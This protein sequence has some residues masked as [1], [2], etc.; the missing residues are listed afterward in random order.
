MDETR[1]QRWGAASGF[2]AILVGAAAT[3][4]ER[5]SVGV[6]DSAAKIAAHLVDNGQALRAQS[7]L[8]VIGTGALLWFM[9]SLRSFLGMAEGGSTRLSEVAFGAGVAWIT[10]SL[11]AQTFQIGLAGA[12]GGEVS[13]ALIATMDASFVVAGLPLAVMLIA[14]AAVSLRTKVFPAWLAWLS[15]AT[16][17]AQLVSLLGIVVA[18]GPL[19]LD[20]WIT[21]YTPYPLLVVWLTATSAVMVVRLG[22]PRSAAAAD[23]TPTAPSRR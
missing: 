22:K 15:M 9:G 10:L 4:F 20:G 1:R 18:S 14:N 17:A 6:D 3:A 16:A 21:L 19:A 13:P 5:G 12:A 8:F 7:L 23:G 2:A 11:V